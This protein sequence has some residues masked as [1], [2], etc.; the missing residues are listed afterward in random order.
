M[1]EG[2]LGKG[3]GPVCAWIVVCLIFCA[4][5][6]AENSLLQ[7]FNGDG[8]FAVVGFGD[9][10][11]AGLGDG[12]APGVYVEETGDHYEGGGY[13]GR[14]E[15]LAGIK[16]YNKGFLGE[17]LTD[18]GV[19]R[20]PRSALSMPADVVAF[21]EGSNDAVK[22]VGVLPYR[23]AVQR[24]VNMTDIGGK[25]LVLLTIPSPCCNHG[26]GPEFY[27][28]QY[29]DEMREIAA[30]NQ[31]PLADVERAWRTTCENRAACE[32]FNLPEG[33]HPN[34][35]GYDVIGQVVLA[36]LYGIDIFAE[37]GAQELETALGLAQG[38]VIVKP[39]LP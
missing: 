5:L 34:M 8:V 14:L 24:I 28:T 39:D 21:M 26:G 38:S 17:M 30:I 16:T 1:R 35:R 10:L 7:D 2:T 29:N 32:L 27:T 36:A 31:L 13:L 3:R 15:K 25:G 23:K 6:R 18:Q 20:F 11:T 22:R 4:P 19:W 33:L 12:I 37:G 9:S